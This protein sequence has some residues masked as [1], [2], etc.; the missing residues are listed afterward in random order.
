[1]MTEC[2]PENCQQ[3]LQLERTMSDSPSHAI[4]KA[5]ND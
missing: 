4:I 3:S 1:M 5:N 2:R